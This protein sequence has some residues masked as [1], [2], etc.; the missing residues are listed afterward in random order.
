MEK[1][2]KIPKSNAKKDVHKKYWMND[3]LYKQGLENIRSRTHVHLHQSL[4]KCNLLNDFLH[5]K[6]IIFL[7]KYGRRKGDEKSGK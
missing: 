7:W 4:L 1:K 5:P 3:E 2:K 6:R